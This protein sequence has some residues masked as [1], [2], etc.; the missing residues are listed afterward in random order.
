MFNSSRI[1]ELENKV[2]SLEH[3]IERDIQDR[4]GFLDT[5]DRCVELM[6][7]LS[8]DID[9]LRK[10]RYDMSDKINEI[11]GMIDIFKNDIS[12]I[13]GELLGIA[14]EEDMKTDETS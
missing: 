12:E 6:K 14:V 4:R 13:R 8:S 2:S 11:E 7:Q 3:I 5:M 9:D 10:E 1:A